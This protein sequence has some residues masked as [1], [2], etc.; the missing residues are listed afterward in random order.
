MRLNVYSTQPRYPSGID[1]I[2]SD[3][4]VAI[5]DSERVV[6]FVKE[7]IIFDEVGGEN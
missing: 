5:E 1:L 4:V 2:E 7:R 6:A 3:M